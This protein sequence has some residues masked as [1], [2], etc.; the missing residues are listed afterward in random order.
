MTTPATTPAP[1]RVPR[2]TYRLQFNR[3]FKLRRAIELVPYLHELGISHIYAS[4]LLKACP[5]STH[6]YDTCDHSQ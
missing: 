2:A 5:G 3:D 1:Q 6:G 4:P